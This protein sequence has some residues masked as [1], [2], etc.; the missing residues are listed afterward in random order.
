MSSSNESNSA[1]KCYWIF[2]NDKRLFSGDVNGKGH[3]TYDN[4]LRI[5]KKAQVEINGVFDEK[6]PWLTV[7]DFQIEGVGKAGTNLEIDQNGFLHGAG[8]F[9]ISNDYLGEQLAVLFY[10][11][12]QFEEF[13]FSLDV[14]NEQSAVTYDNEQL[15]TAF[16][17]ARLDFEKYR[18]FAEA[19]NLVDKIVD[20]RLLS[21][22]A[23]RNQ[24]F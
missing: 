18:H 10:L 6:L 8:K 17:E 15:K 7:G 16:A 2:E 9:V 23:E 1:N 19:F 20:L 12:D 4:V 14:D 5:L 13:S 22:N 11:Q 21:S 24:Y 3:V